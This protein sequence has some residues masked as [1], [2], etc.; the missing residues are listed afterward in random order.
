MMRYTQTHTR[1]FLLSLC[2][3]VEW[4]VLVGEREFVSFG[5]SFPCHSSLYPLLFIFFFPFIYLFFFLFFFLITQSLERVE[6]GQ[7][8][9]HDS[10]SFSVISH[11]LYVQSSETVDKLCDMHSYLMLQYYTIYTWLFVFSPLIFLSTHNL[12]RSFLPPG[13][14]LSSYSKSVK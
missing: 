4:Y 11:L 14:P 5:C 3:E 1:L 6:R 9:F 12:V 7:G 10:L 13:A 8:Y 2:F